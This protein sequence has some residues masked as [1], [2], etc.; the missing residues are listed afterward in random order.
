[1]RHLFV[2][3]FSLFYLTNFSQNQSQKEIGF[4][5]EKVIDAFAIIE[6]TYNVKI[7]FTDKIIEGKR[8]SITARSLNLNELL[9]I[10]SDK[11]SLNFEFLNQKY[12]SVTE[13]KEE[14]QPFIDSSILSE[15][16]IN[17]YLA[18]GISKNKNAIYKINPKELEILPGLIEAD[19]LESL[20]ELPG[21]NS[22]NETATGLN[23]RGG[24]P[25]QNQIIWDGINIFHSGHFFGM[26]SYFNP[27]I[28]S[29]IEFL[30]KGVN[31]KYGDRISSVIN[32]S[33]S[34]NVA[35]KFNGGAGLNGISG[36]IFLE[37]PIIK[38]K[39][40]VMVSFRKSMHDYFSS[41]A[42]ENF[43][44]KVF[45]S[46]VIHSTQ[47]SEEIFSF[48]DMT[49]KINYLLNKNN[50][51]LLSYINIDNN[52]NHYNE[53]IQNKE[54]YQ[55]IL[56][57][58]NNGFSA[59]WK[60]KWSKKI[61]Q[62][63]TF[64]SSHFSHNYDFITQTSTQVNKTFN[65]QNFVNNKFFST[66]LSIHS[67]S[68]N[69]T[70]VGLQYDFKNIRYSFREVIDNLEFILD[71]NNNSI[72]TFSFFAE[73]KN[74]TFSFFDFNVGVRGNY[75]EQFKK[76]RIEPRII[77]TKKLFNNL[78]FQASAD[79]KN[80]TINQ[81][82]ET[83]ISNLSLENKLWRLADDN[84]SPII[85]SQQ[86]T[87]GVL[88]DFNG[89][90][91]DV[92]SYYKKNKGIS[93]LKLGFQSN[94]SNRFDIGEQYISGIDFYLKKNFKHFKTWISYSYLDIKNKFPN[95]KENEFFTA[96]NEIQQGISSSIAY[97]TRK[98]QL[99]FGWKWHSGTPFTKLESD[100]I[101]DD[102]INE[103][104]LSNYSRFDVSSVYHFLISKKNNI[105]GKIGF[106]VRNLFNKNN[107][108]SRE[109]ISDN[110]SNSQLTQIDK[111]S[112][113]KTTNFVLR[114]E[115]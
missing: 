84:E 102:D 13:K 46:T 17:S 37:T 5:N 27:N 10:F 67:E 103:E 52:L 90:S 83:L 80:Q 26:I 47:N 49:Y 35:E 70:L 14:K 76:F 12:I 104:V 41:N 56:D 30:N 68:N 78:K 19:I 74:R 2:V 82:D 92:D 51:F 6:K 38:D 21:V 1:M 4:E 101:L 114:F 107:Q 48:N 24:T 72:N 63:T 66:E 113:K 75:Y 61:N 93:A 86:F 60:K 59:T 44:D 115:W 29:D 65:K 109:Y 69:T 45:Q 57:T 9:S 71:K 91:F 40:S 58:E 50:L 77:I 62:L 33:T 22:P 108:L 42:F 85:N 55:D 53:N 7:S 110:L 15:I 8:I 34:D 81:I 3:I 98:F 95:I 111:F 87:A 73:H 64:S 32:I 39:L 106:S 99:A 96:N 43:E 54:L 105:R 36:D 16:L 100:G 94:N 18:K 112:L 97:K 28:T 11:L 23:V 89:W 79:I 20:Q 31:P 88:Y 25:D